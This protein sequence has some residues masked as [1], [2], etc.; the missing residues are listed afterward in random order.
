MHVDKC[1]NVVHIF[2]ALCG[3]DSGK[4]IVRVRAGNVRV[5]TAALVSHKPGWICL[6]EA[7]PSSIEPV[8]QLKSTRKVSVC[9]DILLMREDPM[10]TLV[11]R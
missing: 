2:G 7:P 5:A 6:I 3:S 4:H 9:E 11:D 8:A 1:A 10:G